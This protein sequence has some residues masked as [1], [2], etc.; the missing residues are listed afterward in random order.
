MIECGLLLPQVIPQVKI[1]FGRKS[2]DDVI[3]G[4]RYFIPLPSTRE[5]RY[6]ISILLKISIYVRILGRCVLVAVLGVFKLTLLL[7]IIVSR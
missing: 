5:V 3:L 2:L 6:R 1:V 4:S 7:Q